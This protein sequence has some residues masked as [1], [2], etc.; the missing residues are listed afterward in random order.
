MS[1]AGGFIYTLS[2]RK[3]MSIEVHPSLRAQSLS[4]QTQVAIEAALAAAKIVEGYFIKGTQ[5]RSKQDGESYN[6]V[7]DADIEAERAVVETIRRVFPD[8]EIIGEEG[9]VGDRT[10]EH[11]WVVDPLDGT[12]NFAHRIPQFSVSIAYYQSGKAASGVVVNPISGDWYWAERG[13][14][15]YHNGRRLQVSHETTLAGSMVGVG[16]YYDRG[17]MMEATLAAIHSFFKQ[18]IHGIRRFGSAALDL[19]YV[20]DG[21][22]GAFFE[23]QLSPWDFAAGRL[24]VEEAGGKI[25][26]CKGEELE[27]V[28]SSVLATNGLLHNASLDIVKAHHIF[29]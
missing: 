4:L 15:A 17:A 13:Q 3:I 26:T 6:L 16:F 29:P 21:M 11:V 9:S 19:C 5:A 1:R 24:L 8:H 7:T 20:A 22:F 2:C 23:Y 18:Q 12:N 14:G 10:A 28:S 25:T 27:L